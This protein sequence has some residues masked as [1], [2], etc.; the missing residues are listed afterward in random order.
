M[1]RVTFAIFFILN[2]FNTQLKANDSTL[3]LS[4]I[5]SIQ[6]SF[7][8]FEIDN[9]NNIYIVSSNNQIKKINQNF[10]SLAVFNDTRRFGNIHLLDVN[11]PLKILVFYKE[12]STIVV[13]DRFL[14]MINT[15][16]LRKQ[17]L[18]QVSCIATSYD[19]KI[20]LFDELENKIIKIDDLGN[21]LMETTD[22]RMLFDYGFI[23][24]KI[25]DE[26]G[27][28][29]CYNKQYGL[30]VFD[31]YGGLKHKYPIINYQYI[32]MH[33][34][35]FTGFKKDSVSIIKLNLLKQDNFKINLKELMPIKQATQINKLF[36][37]TNTSFNIFNITQ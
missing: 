37:L 22:F 17:N 4:L 34:E 14:N 19:N 3:Q 27:K 10:D 29:Y 16:D 23:T 1:G 31:Y 12:F 15:I 11:N 26:N 7:K 21:K 25:V 32:Q 24:E 35:T 18:L 30:I 2:V 8:D 33:N 13:L 36:L 9:L 5:K 28:L 6:G 20:W